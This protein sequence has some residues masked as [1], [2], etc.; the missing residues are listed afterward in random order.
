MLQVHFGDARQAPGV[1]AQAELHRKEPKGGQWP[2]ATCAAQGA[3]GS[4]LLEQQPAPGTEV[5][6]WAHPPLGFIF[7]PDL[8]AKA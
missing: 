4:C 7:L 3:P 6:Y 8:G 2:L 1:E 5:A